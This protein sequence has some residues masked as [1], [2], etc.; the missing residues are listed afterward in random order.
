VTQLLDQ[1]QQFRQLN[2]SRFLFQ[3]LEQQQL[4]EALLRFVK[5]LQ[6]GIVTQVA[7]QVLPL[8]RLQSPRVAA[9]EVQ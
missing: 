4:I 5:G 3:V 7:L 1:F 2:S 9:H 6:G 8:L